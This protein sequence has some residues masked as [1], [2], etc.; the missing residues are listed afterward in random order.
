MAFY[1]APKPSMFGSGSAVKPPLRPRVVPLTDEQVAAQQV[2]AAFDPILNNLTSQYNARGD[3][4]ARAITGSTDEL[5][6]LMGGYGPTAASAYDRAASNEAAINSVL[7]ATRQGQGADASAALAGK[8]G[9]ID[10]GTTARVNGGLTGDLAGESLAAATRGT[11]NLAMLLGQGASAADFGAKL[12]G[13]AGGIGLNANRTA[14]GQITNELSSQLAALA[15]KEPQAVQ[16][17]LGAIQTN[18]NQKSQLTFEHAVALLNAGAI[19]AK[20][21]S[22]MTGIEAT[23]PLKAQPKPVTPKIV[24]TADGTVLAVN[25]NT[26][27]TVATISGPKPPGTPKQMKPTTFQGT[28]GRTYVYNPATG[29]AKPIAGQSAPKPPKKPG[30]STTGQR[31]QAKALAGARAAHAGTT[32]GKGT[33]H[34]P[35]SWQQFLTEGL[36]EGIPARYLIAQGRRVYSQ[37]EIHQG[38]I[39]KA[40]GQ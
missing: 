18:R 40:P 7:A 11:N 26:G 14:Q 17:A 8:L 22:K 4:Q 29:A 9:G 39:P 31:W 36:S 15:A 38:L 5:A 33:Y 24:H 10:S 32:D 23:T 35:I 13:I 20:Q 1:P 28:D 19:S 6:R 25:P 2:R 37:A 12:P 27:Q 3:A 30:D 16:D 21:F 34:P